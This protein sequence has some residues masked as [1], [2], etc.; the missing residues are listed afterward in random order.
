[1]RLALLGLLLCSCG[2]TTRVGLGAARPAAV[3]AEVAQGGLF[4]RNRLGVTAA[5]AG[6][7]G[8][9]GFDPSAHLQVEYVRVAP[10]SLRVGARG[11]AVWTGDELVPT[12]GPLFAVT[13]RLDKI[14]KAEQSVGLQVGCDLAIPDA[15]ESCAALLVWQLDAPRAFDPTPAM[16]IY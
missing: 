2:L 7:L 10:I 13:L 1:M 11:G 14:K 6:T 16:P 3:R 8:D 15:D 5:L 9:A 12:A 4:V